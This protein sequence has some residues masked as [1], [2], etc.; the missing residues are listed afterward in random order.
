M[1]DNSGAVSQA[2]LESQRQALADAFGGSQHTTSLDG[3]AMSPNESRRL[4]EAQEAEEAARKRKEEEERPHLRAVARGR[5]TSLGA[6]RAGLSVEGGPGTSSSA[7]EATQPQTTRH[8][9]QRRLCPRA[10]TS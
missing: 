4:A 5:S 1:T 2:S 3:G 7:A 6:S 9:S 8:T 10:G